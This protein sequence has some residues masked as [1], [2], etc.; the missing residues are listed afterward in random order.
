MKSIIAFSSTLALV[1]AAHAADWQVLGS[2]VAGSL[3][4][5]RSTLKRDGKHTSVWI[6]EA[7]FKPQ[8]D[9]VN[10]E[11]YDMVLTK[12]KIDCA[13]DTAVVTSSSWIYKGVTVSSS[14]TSPPAGSIEPDSVLHVVQQAVCR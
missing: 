8:S 5:E 1:G 14:D 9:P 2:G 11:R 12:A 6:R 13:A 4:I 3:S 10:G 7:Y